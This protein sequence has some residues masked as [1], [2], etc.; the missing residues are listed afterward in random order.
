MVPIQQ[1]Y[2]TQRAEERKVSQVTMPDYANVK[3]RFKRER[4]K[5]SRI[6][7]QMFK[8][9]M[10]EDYHRVFLRRHYTQKVC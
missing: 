8:F 1:L 5:E 10:L 6:V 7:S 3:D 4:G 2:E 9:M